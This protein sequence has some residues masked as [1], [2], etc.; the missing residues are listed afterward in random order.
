[1]IL[2]SAAVRSFLMGLEKDSAQLLYPNIV[3][4]NGKVFCLNLQI[5]GIYRNGGLYFFQNV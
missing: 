1:M 4:L 5:L 2:L 3:C